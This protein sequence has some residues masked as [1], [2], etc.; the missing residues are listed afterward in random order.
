EHLVLGQLPG[1]FTGE[2]LPVHTHRARH[3][4][5]TAAV[6]GRDIRQ[7]PLPQQKTTGEETGGEHELGHF[8][9]MELDYLKCAASSALTSSGRSRVGT[10]APGE[11]TSAVAGPETPSAMIC[12]V[13]GGVEGSSAP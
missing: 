4:D 13:S 2:V 6:R 11:S 1:Q 7:D 8:L 5:E 3:Q 10:C 12:R 9:T